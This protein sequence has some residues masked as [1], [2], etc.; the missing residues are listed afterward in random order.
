VDPEITNIRYEATVYGSSRLTTDLSLS[1]KGFYL[2]ATAAVEK[3]ELGVQNRYQTT[4]VS[5]DPIETVTTQTHRSG[6]WPDFNLH[7]GLFAEYDIRIN[8]NI[9]LS[10]RVFGMRSHFLRDRV[11]DQAFGQG[12]LHDTFRNHQA[13]GFGLKFKYLLSPS[14]LLQFYASQSY[15][16]IDATSYFLEIVPETY[17]LEYRTRLIGVGLQYRFD[18]RKPE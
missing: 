13:A 16:S 7:Y 8:N 9:R 1:F 12:S 3:L 2:G 14:L 17:R 5:V 10:P 18:F 4:L 6:F 15:W 11:F